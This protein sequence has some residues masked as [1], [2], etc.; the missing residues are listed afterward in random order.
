[1]DKTG[2]EYIRGTAQVQQS[3]DEVGKPRLRWFGDTGQ[4][5]VNMGK[6]RKTSE[7][8]ME[9]MKEHMQR[10]DVT[11]DAEVRSKQMIHS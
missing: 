6:K 1:M 8:I 3:G 11:E 9:V 4:R 5:I 7:K 10:V 2:N